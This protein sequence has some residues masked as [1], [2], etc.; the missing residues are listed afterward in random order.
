M[1]VGLVVEARRKGCRILS[2]DPSTFADYELNSTMSNT[3]LESTEPAVT[4][5][6][7]VASKQPVAGVAPVDDIMA[8]CAKPFIDQKLAMHILNKTDGSEEGKEVLSWMRQKRDET[9][10]IN[11]ALKDLH[12]SNLVVASENAALRDRLSGTERGFRTMFG[13]A[14]KN[15]EKAQIVT[16]ETAAQ[17]ANLQMSGDDLHRITTVLVECGARAS[18]RSAEAMN[19][20]ASTTASEWLAEEPATKRVKTETSTPSADV[21]AMWKSLFA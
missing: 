19:P 5:V 8:I 12:S 18:K 2:F 4:S 14:L 6:L 21:E 3:V 1:D 7:T 9:N 17:A 13:D 11:T 16:P 10:R 15:L 20:T